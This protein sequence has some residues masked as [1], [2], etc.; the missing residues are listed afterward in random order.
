[1]FESFSI[2]AVWKTVLHVSNEK[3]NKLWGNII[4]CRID[5]KKLRSTSANSII[6]TI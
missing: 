2:L 1:M 3:T 4:K 5:N 6:H